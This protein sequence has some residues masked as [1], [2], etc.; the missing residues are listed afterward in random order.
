MIQADI[1]QGFDIGLEYIESEEFGFVLTLS[2]GVVR[3]TWFK[4]LVEVDGDE[5]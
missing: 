1:I 4:D 5:E 2:L 3:F